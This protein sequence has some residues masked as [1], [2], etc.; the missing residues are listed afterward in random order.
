[1][2]YYD[3]N[4]YDSDLEYYEYKDKLSP[5]LIN[6]F[7]TDKKLSIINFYK[8]ILYLESEF[9]GIRNI[10]SVDILY[11]IETTTKV[12]KLHKKD[13]SLTKD[14]L[15]IFNNMYYDLYGYTNS[16]FVYNQITK[17][18]FNK[19]YVPAKRFTG[20]EIKY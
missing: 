19:I 5:E 3:D 17:K 16:I 12:A 2:N 20:L 1:M 9:I 18:I 8:N 4:E 10:S 14:Q 15:R 7:Q 11:I 13:Y 6:E